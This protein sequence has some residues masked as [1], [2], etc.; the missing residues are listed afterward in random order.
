MRDYSRFGL[1]SL[2][3]EC[4]EKGIKYSKEDTAENLRQ[5]LSPKPK[6]PKKPAK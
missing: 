5:K 1:V 3:D 6:K 4:E 2:R